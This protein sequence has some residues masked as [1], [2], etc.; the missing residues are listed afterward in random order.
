[1]NELQS[2]L[3]VLA[4][5]RC[6]RF[7]QYFVLVFNFLIH[8]Q[9]ITIEKIE[10]T[11]LSISTTIH[12][13]Q[14]LLLGCGLGVQGPHRLARRRGEDFDR[15]TQSSRRRCKSEGL[16][17]AIIV[18]FVADGINAKC[19]SILSISIYMLRSRTSLLPPSV[20]S[21]SRV[22]VLTGGGATDTD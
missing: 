10:T 1:M 16:C 6:L 19:L 5:A 2:S 7:V 11:N 18:F 22:T 9:P 17:I 20:Q 8:Q 21:Q 12:T 13:S 14:P 3:G 4:V 15:Q